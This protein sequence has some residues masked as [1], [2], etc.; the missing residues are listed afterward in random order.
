MRKINPGDVRRDFDEQL[1]ALGAFYATGVEKF[2]GAAERSTFVE[3]CMLV[4]AVAWEGFANDMFIAYIN[5]D[6]T[7]FKQ[8]L[9]DALYA[10]LSDAEKPKKVFD[11]FA[12][13]SF[14]NHLTKKQVQEFADN[15]GSNITFSSFEKLEEKSRVWLVPADAG[16]FTNVSN[17]QKAV[18]NAVIALRNH[19]AH[20]SERSSRAMNTKLAMGELH[21]TG[22][23]RGDNKVANVGAWLKSKPIGNQTTRFSLF[24]EE[25]RV[26]GAAV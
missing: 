19:I 17:R 8:H 26:I 11:N 10:H 21:G 9:K 15:E 20:R 13:L 4:L 23:Q 14:P 25:L 7:R 12:D 6:A 3:N 24:L 18:V 2:A 16:R 1:T 5:G 22:L